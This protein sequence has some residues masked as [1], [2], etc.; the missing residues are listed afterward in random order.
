MGVE[1]NGEGLAEIVIGNAIDCHPRHALVEFD[2]RG[3]AV[4]FPQEDL[5]NQR[6]RCP[7]IGE[8]IGDESDLLDIG[9]GT[10]VRRQWLPW[11]DV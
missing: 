6:V 10:R 7:A 2:V 4:S 9:V 1:R 5:G 11:P 8:R 3:Q